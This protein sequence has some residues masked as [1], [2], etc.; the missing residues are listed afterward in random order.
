MEIVE[1][2][3]DSVLRL[4]SG[5]LLSPMFFYGVMKPARDV[6][7]WRV[8]Q[9]E[10]GSL[11]ILAVPRPDAPQDWAASL[12]R[13]VEERLGEKA[14]VEIVPLE[15][16]PPDSSGKVRAVISKMSAKKADRP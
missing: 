7:A 1:G 16:I 4:P 3:A 9:E 11:T 13:H 12:R 5:R 10:N 6:G 15:T 8:V 14:A 2:R